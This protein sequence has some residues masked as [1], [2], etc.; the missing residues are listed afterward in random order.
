MAFDATLPVNNSPIVAAEL[1][2]QFNALKALMDAQAAQLAQ[3]APLTPV[4]ARDNSGNW[5]LAFT[6]TAPASWQ[7]WQR[8]AAN[9]VWTMSTHLGVNAFPL[10]DADM[11]PGGVW[12]QVKICGED[13]DYLAATPFSNTISFGSVPP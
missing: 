11:A 1:R 10:T 8:N 2:N 6:A 12:W 7:L 5:T 3:L 13:Q 9:P 4:L